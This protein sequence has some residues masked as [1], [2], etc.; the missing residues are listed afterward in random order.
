MLSV[1]RSRLALP[2]QLCFLCVHSIGLL[3]GSIYT[4]N[5]PNLYENNSHNRIGWIVTWAVVGQCVIGVIRLAANLGKPRD[6][7]SVEERAAFL[8]VST[9]AMAQHGQTNVMSSPDPYRYS[10]DSGHFTASRSQ[11]ISSTQD[12]LDEEEHQQKLRDYEAAHNG[13]DA[14]FT[15][16]RGLLTNPKVER[17]A[18][19]I[20]ALISERTMKFLK[21]VHN[22]VDRLILLPGF[23]TFI[24]GAAVY[25]GAFVSLLC[26]PHKN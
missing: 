5:T 7:H 26:K 2:V 8:P 12:P 25:G 1:A 13:G 21:F 16:K 6:V 17:F 20:S 4:H 14:L 10:N 11:S 18:Q 3:L 19:K 9:E 15:E 24:S 23:I 22:A